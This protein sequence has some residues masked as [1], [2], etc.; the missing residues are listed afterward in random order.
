MIDLKNVL[1][2]FSKIKFHPDFAYSQSEKKFF[3]LQQLF[4]LPVAKV[5]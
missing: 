1:M 4:D 2:R 5:L 3:F